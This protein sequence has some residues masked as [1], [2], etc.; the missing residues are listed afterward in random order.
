MEHSPHIIEG[1]A[2]SGTLP[3]TDLC[4]AG[5]QQTFNIC[6]ENIGAD[7]FLENGLQGF[8]MFRSQLWFHLLLLL[9]SGR[10]TIDSVAS[11]PHKTLYS[12]G[13]SCSLTC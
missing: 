7:R 5:D 3:F 12:N 1:N 11:F 6:P 9:V 4:S 2:Y 10:I 8:A 13:T